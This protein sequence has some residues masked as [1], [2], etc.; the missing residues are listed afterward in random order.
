[1]VPN[2]HLLKGDPSHEHGF[3]SLPAGIEQ[4]SDGMLMPGLPVV[5]V[6]MQMLSLTQPNRQRG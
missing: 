3:S 2:R 1:M 4:H 6:K 5:L